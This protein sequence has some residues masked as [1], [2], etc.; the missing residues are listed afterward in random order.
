MLSSPLKSQSLDSPWYIVGVNR[1]YAKYFLQ[2]KEIA[3]EKLDLFKIAPEFGLKSSDDKHEFCMW[4]E[5]ER[6]EIPSILTGELKVNS[7]MLGSLVCNWWLILRRTSRLRNQ[8]LTQQ[9]Q[10]SPP[11]S[12]LSAVSQEEEMLCE[13]GEARKERGQRE[14]RRSFSMV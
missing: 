9:S 13:Q 1:I 3:L 6:W 11:Q 10:Q 14:T 8:K 4:N 5:G 7:P 12:P 2:N